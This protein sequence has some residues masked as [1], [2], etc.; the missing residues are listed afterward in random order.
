MT[1]VEKLI[2]QLHPFP[3]PDI[4]PPPL[5]PTPHSTS[6]RSR[7]RHNLAL[8]VHRTAKHTRDA[9]NQLFT[10]FAHKNNKPYDPSKPQS[11]FDFTFPAGARNAGTRAPRGPVSTSAPDPGS[12]DF[13]GFESSSLFDPITSTTTASQRRLLD[14]I[15][16][17]ANRFVRRG[18]IASGNSPSLPD[19][20]FDYPSSSLG[21]SSFSYLETNP[22][23]P[24]ASVTAPELLERLPSGN[25]EVSLA[26]SSA[27]PLI[28][29]DVA[30]PTDAGRVA[31]DELLPD[32]L[33]SYYNDPRQCLARYATTEVKAVPVPDSAAVV[34]VGVGT[35]TAPVTPKPLP[36]PT[37]YGS[38]AEYL[39]LTLRLIDS[40]MIV[41]TTT[42]EVVNGLSCR[43]KPNGDLRLIIDARWANREFLEPPHIELPTP[44]LFAKVVVPPP[45]PGKPR[46]KIW[47]AKTDLSDYYYNIAIPEWMVP[48]FALPPLLVDLVAAHR[49]SAVAAFAPGTM[50]HPCLRVLAMGWSHSVRV[51]QEAHTNQLDTRTTLCGAKDRINSANDLRL[52]TREQPNGERVLHACYID[53]MEFLGTD[54]IRVAAAQ[55]EYLATMAQVQIPAKSSKTV[56][57]STSGVEGLGM[58]I[59]GEDHTVGVSPAKLRALCD[60]TS[61]LLQKQHATGLEVA[62]CVGRWT[63]AMLVAR[64]ALSVFNAVYKFIVT[65]GPIPFEIWRSVRRELWT[66]IRLAPLLVASLSIDWFHSVVASDAS[67]TGQ[68][69]C[70][71]RVSDVGTQVVAEAAAHSGVLWKPDQE[72]EDRINSALFT[73]SEARAGARRWRTIVSGAFRRPEHIN[74]LEL[75]SVLTAVRWVLTSPDSINRRLLLLSDSQVAVGALTKGRTSAHFL[76]RRLRPISALLLASGIQLSVRWIPSK[77]NPADAPSRRYEFDATLGYPGEGPFSF[78]SPRPYHRASAASRARAQAQAQRNREAA[79]KA[80]ARARRPPGD[81]RARAVATGTRSRYRR[82]VL[83]FLSWAQE[84]TGYGDPS[85]LIEDEADLDRLLTEYVQYMYDDGGSKTAAKHAKSGLCHFFPYLKPLLPNADQALRGWAKAE[86]AVSYPPLTWELASSLAV[87][88]SNR[89]EHA[90]HGIGVVL[91]FDCLLR[92]SE[93]VN[94]KREDVAFDDG[95]KDDARLGARSHGSRPV[96]A[97]AAQLI[98]NLEAATTTFASAPAPPISFSAGTV[99][100]KAGTA[101]GDA[102]QT[103]S[104]SRRRTGHTGLRRR[105]EVDPGTLIIIRRAKTGRNQNVVLHD[106]S[107]TKLLRELV[108]RTRPGGYLFPFSAAEFRRIFKKGCADLGL[109][110]L[111]VPHSLR[112]GGATRYHHRLGWSMEDVMLRG[113]WVSSKSA[114][115]YI[116]ASVAHAMSVQVPEELHELG[117]V[118]SH[119][120]D[121]HLSLARQDAHY[122]HRY[123]NGTPIRDAGGTL[124]RAGA[125]ALA[126]AA[127]VTNG[128]GAGTR[129]SAT[130]SSN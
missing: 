115:T 90:R 107:L 117:Y 31:M 114:R 58:V 105:G 33:R 113:R 76:L 108:D 20:L 48:F 37:V 118:F 99:R 121:K 124:T 45:E 70:A 12:S 83:A 119:A 86:P 14:R 101:D 23:A 5:G 110:K 59:N 89:P 27:V 13:S 8:R 46:T 64:P 93:L 54:P 128:V 122:G 92:V 40:K 72:A 84:A 10:S 85:L 73:G 75:R 82:A 123:I 63:W 65:A 9:L 129:R 91:A 30:L 130:N 1:G 32:A 7:A 3:L 88:I 102:G 103:V 106:T 77:L 6:S 109:S 57:P 79:R 52:V 71:A 25:Y 41:F 36:K 35:G 125:R 38:A 47:V 87:H 44:D 53:D 21:H 69:V 95:V 111:Y 29:R 62:R 61:A 11:G 24:L 17:C 42:P 16:H 104:K 19:S 43:R 39:K 112:H 28:A 26:A 96:A 49:P 66:A 50:V 67:L 22:F 18:D 98:S 120:L 100:R 94:L 97:A 56:R 15:H 51:A 78:S 74:E 81:L 68:G 80:K 127:G 34:G 2:P 126:A 55:D 60:A 4:G 116:Q